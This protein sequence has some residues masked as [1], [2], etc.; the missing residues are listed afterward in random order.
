MED[1]SNLDVE[2]K[3]AVQYVSMRLEVKEDE[4]NKNLEVKEYEASRA[5][6]SYLCKC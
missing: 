2:A 4:V 5:E 1:Q 3:D 6:H